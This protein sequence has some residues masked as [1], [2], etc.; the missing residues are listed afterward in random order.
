L[1][2]HTKVVIGADVWRRQ[3][4]QWQCNVATGAPQ[5]S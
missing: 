5:Y 4:S 2:T 3:L 1:E